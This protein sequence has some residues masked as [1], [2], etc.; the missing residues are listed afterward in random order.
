MNLLIFDEYFAGFFFSRFS[1]KWRLILSSLRTAVIDML[2][3]YLASDQYNISLKLVII[4]ED[5]LIFS[6]FLIFSPNWMNI[7]VLLRQANKQRPFGAR[8]RGIT[9]ITASFTQCSIMIFF[10][11]KEKKKLN[12]QR[13]TFSIEK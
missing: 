1:H 10:K 5:W 6:V 4:F 3:F 13:K 7:V 9:D 2:L 12:Q 8:F 11:K